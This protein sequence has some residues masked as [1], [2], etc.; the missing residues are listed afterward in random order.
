[1]KNKEKQI[2]NKNKQRKTKK[3]KNA[4]QILSNKLLINSLTQSIYLLK[5]FIISN[6]ERSKRAKMKIKQL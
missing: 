1:M 3:G 2:K 5:K 4:Q 6:E